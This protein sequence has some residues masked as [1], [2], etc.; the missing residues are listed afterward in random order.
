MSHVR[1]ADGG[2]AIVEFALALPILMLMVMGLIAGGRL[3]YDYVTV[4]N[5]A[6]EGVRTG[7][8]ASATD[9]EILDA[10][11]GHAGGLGPLRGRT[12]ITPPTARESSAA[13]TVTV[14]YRFQSITPVGS[15][16]GV[17]DL[18]GTS[19]GNVE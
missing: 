9:A 8:I 4:G 11:D 19:T 3:I 17:I 1:R 7:I 2:Q 10:V 6:R 16:I 15:L 12:T 5:A 13:V 14:R 18:A